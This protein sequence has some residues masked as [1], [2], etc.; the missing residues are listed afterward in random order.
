M[1]IRLVI[2]FIFCLLGG[3]NMAQ[4][5]T[6]ACLPN[7][8]SAYAYSFVFSPVLATTTDN[9]AGILKRSIYNW[10]LGGT[11]VATCD[12]TTGSPDSVTYVKTEIPAGLPFDHDQDGLHFYSLNN[13]LSIATEV[14]VG[15]SVNRT[16]P[17]PFE[18]SNGLADKCTNIRFSS[19]ATGSLSLY[20]IRPFVGQI[21]IPPTRVVN[22]YA[23]K[24]QGSYSATPMS[25]VTMSGTVTVP[26]SCDINAGQLVSVNLNDILSSSIKTK[27]AIP[28]GFAPRVVNFTLA[29]NNIS[30]GITLQLSIKGESS[31]GDTTALKT[32]NDDIGIRFLN[33]SGETVSLNDGRLPVTMNYAAQTGTS[34]MSVAPV[35]VTGNEPNVGPFSAT[36]TINVEIQ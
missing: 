6:G 27:G 2:I 22:V 29:C 31:S 1:N 23:S 24:Y 3:V 21:V 17:T 20:F 5:A 19:G 14:Y 15:G 7:T 8:G 32:N 9:Q 10:D 36:A 16:F 13:Y 11:F 12:C 34:T 33:S 25:Y 18:V 28:A 35:N 26:Q 30:Q 4:A